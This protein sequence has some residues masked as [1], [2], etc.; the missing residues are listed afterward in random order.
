MPLVKKKIDDYDKQNYRL[1]LD[2]RLLNPGI[3]NATYLPFA[4]NS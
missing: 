3:E 2:L 4:K 1:A